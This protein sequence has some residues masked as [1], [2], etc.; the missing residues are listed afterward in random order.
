MALW[1]TLT[2]ARTTHGPKDCRA[3]DEQ[4]INVVGKNNSKIYIYNIIK[5]YID[6]I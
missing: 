5:K 6:K 2:V 3:I 1:F 4:G